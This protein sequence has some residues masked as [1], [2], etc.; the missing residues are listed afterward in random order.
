MNLTL[1]LSSLRRPHIIFN[2]PPTHQLQPLSPTIFKSPPLSFQ[3]QLAFL[4][5]TFNLLLSHTNFNLLAG[6][7]HGRGQHGDAHG[8]ARWALPHR[9]PRVHSA[10]VAGEYTGVST[11]CIGE[12]LQP[13]SL[14]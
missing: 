13:M 2:L 10:G 7:S 1:H 14:S 5:T 6:G 3:L 12:L 11:H 9:R 4:P 8:G